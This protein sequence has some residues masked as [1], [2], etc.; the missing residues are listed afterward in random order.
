VLDDAAVL[1]RGAGQEAGHVDEGDDRDVEAIAEAHEARGL[2]ADS[3]MS[4]QPASTMRLVGDDADG[5]AAR[6]AKPMTMFLAPSGCS[7]KK[8]P[9]S[10][11]LRISSF[12]S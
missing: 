8:S 2:D 3:S 9:S 1:L 5:L 11:T 7:S 6:R 12:M 4:R 10:T